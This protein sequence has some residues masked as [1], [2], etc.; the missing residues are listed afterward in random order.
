MI[1][2]NITNKVIYHAKIFHSL[3]LISKIFTHPSLFAPC[4]HNLS[5]MIALQPLT[6]WN[7]DWKA[8]TDPVDYK[9]GQWW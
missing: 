7:L 4:T 5:T 9:G 6:F 3:L 8:G 2:Q 1:V